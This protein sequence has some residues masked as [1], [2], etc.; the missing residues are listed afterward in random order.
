MLFTKILKFS[1]INTSIK[2]LCAAIASLLISHVTLASDIQGADDPK[3]QTAI[4]QWLSDD[5]EQSLPM[6][7]RLAKD[8]NI[9]ARLLLARIEETDVASKSSR[10]IRNM[11]R[12]QRH[13]LYRSGKNDGYFYPSWL[14][15]EADRGNPLAQA[16]FQ[17]RFTVVDIPLIEKLGEL[18]EPEA[19]NDLIRT[20]GFYG[21]QKELNQ[22]LASSS[23]PIEWRPLLQ[24][25]IRPIEMQAEGRYALRLIAEMTE[26]P[27]PQTFVSTD[28]DTR[29]A[30]KYMSL[31]LPF[32]TVSPESRWYGAVEEWFMTSDNMRPIANLCRRSCPQETTQ[33]AIGVM[34]LQGGYFESIRID[35]PLENIIPHKQ[36]LDS[37]RAQGI[38]LRRAALRR[39]NT[40][41]QELMPIEDL[42][43]SSQCLADLVVQTRLEG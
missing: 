6:I 8:G 23:Y 3:L 21:T 25:Y 1:V 43:K 19:S 27:T 17:A 29:D 28:T 5:D 18:G 33:C 12:E 35:S 24:G 16:L 37:E 15:F 26:A 20:A 14:A 7:S 9:A 41:K 22:L 10:Y 2:M 31:G 30:A 40:F 13:D 34:G 36:F 38:A 39:A 11:S 32:A 42:A 4:Q